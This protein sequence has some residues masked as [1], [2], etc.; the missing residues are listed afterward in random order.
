MLDG[1]NKIDWSKLTHAYGSAAEVP[2]L[3]RDL[4]SPDMEAS[5]NALW[6]LYGNIWHQGT[7]YEA[8]AH[9]VPFLIEII[10]SIPHADRVGIL[11]LLHAIVGGH[12][13][14]EVHQDLDGYHNKR[15]TAEFRAKMER[16]ISWVRAARRAVL[17][18]VPTYIRLLEDSEAN[19]RA[20]AAYLL[21]T[22]FERRPEIEL[23]LRQ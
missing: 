17:Q 9:A 11:G 4:P 1:L 10:E 13:Y 20:M 23:A 12:S 6:E 19:A 14:L 22:C 7:V 8:T 15:N 16:E 3:L 18:G 5:A 21:A 2:D